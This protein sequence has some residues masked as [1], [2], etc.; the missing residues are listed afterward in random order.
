MFLTTTA[1]E[2]W[3][4]G[5]GNLTVAVAVDG[6]QW[7]LTVAVLTVAVE[8]LCNFGIILGLFGVVFGYF[9]GHFMVFYGILTV[10]VAVAI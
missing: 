6:W 4:P 10:A 2:P 8:V 5:S 9:G 7:Q 3:S 1:K